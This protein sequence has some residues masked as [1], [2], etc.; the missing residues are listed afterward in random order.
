M[1]DYVGIDTGDY[2][3]ETYTTHSS[4]PVE[5]GKR[6]TWDGF[7]FGPQPE[8]ISTGLN[9]VKVFRG[10]IGG[11]FVF[12]NGSPPVGATDIVVV[13]EILV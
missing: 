13:A 7:E 8:V 11:N 10:V 1:P 4:L 12:N 5:L 9:L 3:D 6:N 2:N